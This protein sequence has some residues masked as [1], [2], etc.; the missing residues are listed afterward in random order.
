M[1]NTATPSD[2]DAELVYRA[3]ALVESAIGPEFSTWRQLVDWLAAV[4]VDDRVLERFPQ[5]PADIN[6]GRRS[7]TATAS[8]ASPGR[9]SILIHDGSRTALTALHELTHLMVPCHPA[10]GQR[11]R[12]T[13]CELV[14]ITCGIEA[15]AEL[16][17]AYRAMGLSPRSRGWSGLARD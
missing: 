8:L 5:V 7:R 1:T 11:F 12:D 2:P 13:L 4:L 15:S 14:R 10:H 3:E 9:A 16:D 17:A 6:I